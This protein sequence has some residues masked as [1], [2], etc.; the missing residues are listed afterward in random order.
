MAQLPMPQ[1]SRYR[2]SFAMGSPLKLHE[3][4]PREE[5]QKRV[6]LPFTTR[7]KP[8]LAQHDA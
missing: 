4:E 5:E 1:T 2:W 3:S 8:A 6:M 7:A